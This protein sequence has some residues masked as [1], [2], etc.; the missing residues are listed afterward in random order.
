[1]PIK[2]APVLDSPGAQRARM[3]LD[4]YDPDEANRVFR[5]LADL[6]DYC[7]EAGLAPLPTIAVSAEGLAVERRRTIVS[8]SA[9]LVAFS[10]RRLESDL[11]ELRGMAEPPPGEGDRIADEI[12]ALREHLSKLVFVHD[13]E[14]KTYADSVELYGIRY[15][16]CVRALGIARCTGLVLDDSNDCGNHR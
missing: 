12:A 16:R 1:M 8:E 4:S 14:H 2:T 9:R 7:H 15:P 5:L 11:D 6:A 13:P 3:V 10:I